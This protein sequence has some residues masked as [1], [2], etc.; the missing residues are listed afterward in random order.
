MKVKTNRNQVVCPNCG[1]RLELIYVDHV[2]GRCKCKET[3]VIVL[4]Y[5]CECLPDDEVLEMRMSGSQM[6]W[7]R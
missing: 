1:N 5:E 6:Y 4:A 7:I 2:G 3:V